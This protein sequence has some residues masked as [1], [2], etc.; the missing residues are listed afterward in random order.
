MGLKDIFSPLGGLEKL[1][2]TAFDDEDY[3][4]PTKTYVVMYNPTN[5]SQSFHSKWLP[6]EGANTDGKERQFRAIESDNVSFEFLFDATG[7]SPPGNDEGSEL[8][9]GGGTVETV[10]AIEKINEDEHV[11]S[12]IKAFLDITQNIK[13][14]THIPNHL[15]I[16]WGAYEFHGVLESATVNYKLFN[17]SGL[18]IRATVTANFAES[19]SREEQAEQKRLNSTD[20]THK[21]IV[22]AGD[23]LPLIAKDIYGDAALYVE[24][25]KANKLKNFRNLEPGQPLILPPIKK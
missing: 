4:L 9:L 3:N 8:D 21:R 15:Q 18:P 16:N 6:E 19:V 11:D 20:L 17:S 10:S 5:F 22:K 1:K 13:S 7:A 24:I 2:I 14:D 12:A 25:A 23:T